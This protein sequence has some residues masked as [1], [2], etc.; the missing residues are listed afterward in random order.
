M[1]IFSMIVRLTSRL[2]CNGLEK[3]NAHE[4][5]LIWI[6]KTDFETLISLSCVKLN[7]FNYV[8]A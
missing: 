6:N 2:S 1:I 5:I 7:L 8:L 4:Y 3:I